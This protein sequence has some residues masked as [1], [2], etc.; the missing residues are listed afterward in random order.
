M[1]L[2]YPSGSPWVGHVPPVVQTKTCLVNWPTDSVLSLRRLLGGL[3]LGQEDLAFLPQR[4]DDLGL[5]DL[6]HHLALPEDQADAAPAGHADVGAASLPGPVDLTSH[7]RH[8]DVLVEPRQPLLDPGRQAD[9]VHVHPAAAGAGD[10]RDALL[11][12][13]ERLED[14]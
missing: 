5:G 2:T 11:A 13:A 7:H 6:A 8:V 9:Q 1:A 10:E 4:L 3:L 14:L 12:Q